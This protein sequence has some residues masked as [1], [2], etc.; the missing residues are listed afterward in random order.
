MNPANNPYDSLLQKMKKEL[1]KVGE[2]SQAAASSSGLSKSKRKNLQRN[3]RRKAEVK[4]AREDRF[5]QQE[6]ERLHH[7]Q[8]GN[9]EAQRKALPIAAFRKKIIEKFKKNQVLIVKGETGSGKSTQLPQFI[10]EEGLNCGGLIACTQP[11]RIATKVLSQRVAEEKSVSIGADVGY[12]IRFDSCRS[13]DTQILYMTEG[14]LLREMSSSPFLLKYN[15]LILD[16]AH[17]RS[18][19]MDMLLCQIKYVLTKREDLK[20]IVCSATMDSE[21]FSKYFNDAAIINVPGRSF[22]VETT[23]LKHSA[24]NRQEEIVKLVNEIAKGKEHGDILVFESGEKNIETIC[25]RLNP[26]YVP[27]RQR[28]RKGVDDGS[29][30][31]ESEDGSD[32]ESNSDA[33][34]T[35]TAED[36][37]KQLLEFAC[38]KLIPIPLF[39]QMPRYLQNLA[40]VPTPDGYRKVVVATNIAETSLTIN[41][42]R[43]V[44]DSG[45]VKEMHRNAALDSIGFDKL[46]EI[47]IS[48]AEADQRKGRAGRTAPGKCFRMYTEDEFKNMELTTTPRI[49]LTDLSSL[50]LNLTNQEFFKKLDFIDP[51]KKK[52]VVN[53]FMSLFLHGAIDKNG[54]ISNKGKRMLRFPLC[55]EHA[56]LILTACEEDYDCGMDMVKAVAVMNAGSL[57]INKWDKHNVA[58]GFNRHSG[59]LYEHGDIALYVKLLNAFRNST[60]RFDWCFAR[61]IDFEAMNRAELICGQLL[62]IAKGAGLQLTSSRGAYDRLSRAFLKVNYLNLAHVET[63]LKDGNFGDLAKFFALLPVASENRKVRKVTLG[64]DSVLTDAKAAEFI[65]FSNLDSRGPYHFIQDAVVIKREW[66]EELEGDMYTITM[67]SAENGNNVPAVTRDLLQMFENGMKLDEDEPNLKMRYSKTPEYEKMVVKF[68][69]FVSSTFPNYP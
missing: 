14:I 31:A 36:Q 39:G 6:I 54:K 3:Q 2:G 41:G 52:V 37:T 21:K 27:I 60:D 56:D 34:E 23:Y 44:V 15:V 53:T 17:E 67:N 43:F 25:N 48:Q 8:T 5:V 47:R 16:E 49:L 50:F 28:E 64:T 42:I 12:H 68:R 22:K 35:S 30:S 4:R 7:F 10:L 62:A 33:S 38:G 63:P 26:S 66:L 13:K 19:V 57:F 9:I 58:L 55:L 32:S 69:E 40:F 61:R 46:D 11:R 45:Y 1:A 59:Y 18:I 24:G 51:P 29:D 65:A 20:L